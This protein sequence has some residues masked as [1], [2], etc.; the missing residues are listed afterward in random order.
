VSEVERVSQESAYVDARRATCP[1]AAFGFGSAEG[2]ALGS[3]DGEV[4]LPDR[5]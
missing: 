1:L 3:N 5:S 2:A 4:F